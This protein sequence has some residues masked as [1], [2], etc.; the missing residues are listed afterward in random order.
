MLGVLPCFYLLT[1]IQG[2]SGENDGAN[3]LLSILSINPFSEARDVDVSLFS[4]FY[5]RY[6]EM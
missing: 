3:R 6:F 1:Y 5:P 2:Q 4:P